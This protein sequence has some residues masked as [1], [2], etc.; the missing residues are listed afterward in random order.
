LLS[1]RQ[2]ASTPTFTLRGFDDC[3]AE[4]V[5]ENRTITTMDGKFVV[6]FADGNAI[7]S[8]STTSR[9]AK[10]AGAEVAYPLR[11][12]FSTAKGV[13]FEGVAP[14]LHAAALL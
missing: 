6:N 3:F 9:S 5:G 12:Q 7:Q 10:A 8:R 11:G 13:G 2:A 4:V 14:H 1:T